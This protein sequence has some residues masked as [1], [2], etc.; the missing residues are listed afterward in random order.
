MYDAA[1]ALRK[2]ALGISPCETSFSRR[3]FH[4]GDAALRTHLEQ[5]GTAFLQGYHSALEVTHADVLAAR[6][7]E[8]SG[9]ARG[10]AF[11]GAAMA[12]TLLD[13]LTPWRSN[14]LRTF[15]AGPGESHIY[16]VYVGVGW[17]FARLPWRT[18]RPLPRPDPLLKWLVFDGYGFHEGYFAHRRT[19]EGQHIPGHLSGYACNVF[20]QGV[21][22]SLWFVDCAD[23]ERIAAHIAAFPAPR[24]ADLWSGVGLACTYAGGVDTATIASLR[25]AAAPYAAELGQG[26]AFAAQARR[27]AGITMPY[28]ER[29]CDILCGT[30]A[31]S[32]AE[33][34]SYA[35]ADLPYDAPKPAYEIW[36]GKIRAMLTREVAPWPA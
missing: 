36:R 24:R 4:L 7:D 9:E 2:L 29:A 31:R 21:G 16:M 14:R 5:V 15:I 34:T 27:R 3:G 11:E 23:I 12:L 19:I 18:W 1:A 33:V 20:D 17:A 8:L 6:L 35:A 22:R 26:A 10:F 25:N 28:T 13:C 32:A 30:T